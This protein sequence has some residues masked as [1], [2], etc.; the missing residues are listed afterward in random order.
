[1]LESVKDFIMFQKKIFQYLGEKIKQNLKKKKSKW[2][3]WDIIC[4]YKSIKDKI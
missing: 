1:M 4:T 2:F 3:N